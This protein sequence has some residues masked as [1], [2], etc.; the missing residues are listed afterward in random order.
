MAHS[1]PKSGTV[2]PTACHACGGERDLVRSGERTTARC[3]SCGKVEEIAVVCAALE[4]W[5]IVGP[6]GT[7]QT[8]LT[9]AELSAFIQ[10]S[11]LELDDD[12]PSRVE[13]P[14]Q[15]RPVSEIP[16]ALGPKPS[17][18]PG[19][20][21]AKVPPPAKDDEDPRRAW[22]L[23]AAALALVALSIAYAVRS[24]PAPDPAAQ[25][26]AAQSAAAT[27]A[28][29]AT[30]F[31]VDASTL[32]PPDTS[33][34]SATSAV[35]EDAR[36]K[37]AASAKDAETAIDDKTLTL[38]ELL[39][40]ASAAKRGADIARA[41]VLL[42]RALTVS[43]ENLEARTGMGDVA[44]AQGELSKAK[45]SYERALATSPNYSPAL[46]GLGDT[47]WDLG[48]R[49][50]AQRPYKTLV[51]QSSSP[52]ERA[53]VRAASASASSS[54]TSTATPSTPPTPT[55]TVRTL[56]SADIPPP[57]PAP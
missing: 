44:R 55:T 23:P 9:K 7:V 28:L 34:T 13:D 40:H 19:W 5:S 12:A 50:G 38:S 52:P 16:S 25:A 33:V 51:N 8:F 57:A 39:S 29:P 4:K 37:P 48:D 41:K 11:S 15:V 56:T 14:L 49:A 22:L 32:T 6:D 35:P 54:S 42:Q 43:P 46:L 2:V 21:P 18:P 24:S 10:G 36:E 31:V 26:Q 27:P 30:S 3:T 17:I 20:L 1:T 45:A 53:K 47:L